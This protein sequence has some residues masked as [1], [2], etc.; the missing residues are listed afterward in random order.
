[1]SEPRRTPDRR[2]SQNSVQE[3]FRRSRW[4]PLW[5]GKSDKGHDA[6]MEQL[7]RGPYPSSRLEP[8]RRSLGA[9]CRPPRPALRPLTLRQPR[10]PAQGR[11]RRRLAEPTAARRSVGLRSIHLRNWPSGKSSCRTLPRLCPWAC[12][13]SCAAMRGSRRY[14]RLAVWMVGSSFV[15]PQCKERRRSGS[16]KQMRRPIPVSESALLAL[17]RKLDVVQLWWTGAASVSAHGRFT[18]KTPLYRVAGPGFEPGAP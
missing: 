9:G 6:A 17:R 4:R 10:R 15:P 16:G 13:V 3:K 12:G 8:Y 18:C 2:T 7:A 11:G 5:L 1:M 14:K